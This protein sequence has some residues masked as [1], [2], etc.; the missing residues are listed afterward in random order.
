MTADV[1]E[2]ASSPDD[3]IVGPLHALTYVT[4]AGDA[5]SEALTSGFELDCGDWHRDIDTDYL[6]VPSGARARAFFRSEPHENVAIRVVDVDSSQAQV[7]PE[8]SGRFLGG[9]SIGFPMS[10]IEGRERRLKPLGIDSVI[11]RKE[12]EFESP[13]GQVYTSAEIHFVGPENI[14]LLGVQRPEGMPPVGPLPDGA[15]IGAPAYSARC[16]S[17]PSA[18]SGFFADVLGF[19][20][21]RDVNLTVGDRS[22]LRLE[23][24]SEERFIQLFAPGATTGYLV[25]LDHYE[26][27]LDSP[28]SHPG[29]P[30]RG[31]GMWTFASR[32][33]DDVLERVRRHSI[34]ILAESASAGSP[35]LGSRRSI[36]LADPENFPIEILEH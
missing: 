9:L 33:Y 25:L 16:V 13:T 32:R 3:A 15:A 30:N 4:A 22:G 29:P 11:G 18:V 14:Y 19:E 24:G 28:A 23:P 7:R 27:T 10:D 35:L 6:N 20:I 31:I 34:E 1:F 36:V 2:P 17:D 12:L 21:R 26:A 8:V 5:L